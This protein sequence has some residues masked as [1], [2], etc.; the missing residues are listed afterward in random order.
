VRLERGRAAASEAAQEAIPLY[1]RVASALRGQIFAGQWSVGERLPPFE[2]LAADYGVALNTIRKAI[3]LLAD[4]GLVAAARGL[5]TRVLADGPGQEGPALRAAIS[6]P[7][8]LAPGITIDVLESSTV[9][10]LAAE[11]MEPYRMAPRY[12]RTSKTHSLSGTPFALLDIYVDAALYARFPR[13]AERRLKLSRLLRDH[14]DTEIAES[15]EELTVQHATPAIASRLQYPIAAPIVRLRRWR[16]A[17]DRRVVY[18]CVANYRSDLFVFDVT[19]SHLG[20]DH[21]GQHIIPSTASPATKRA[22]MPK[23]SRRSS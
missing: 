9:E 6:D 21:F 7:L 1:L 13:H 15:R 11:L 19:R 8:E 16:L 18:A 20:A 10:Q 2:R 14:G 12:H 4:E 5:G 23:L 17:P 3:E 22:A